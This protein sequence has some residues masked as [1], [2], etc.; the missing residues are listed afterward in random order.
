MKTSQIFYPPRFLQY[1]KAHFREKKRAYFWHFA[2]I[3]MMYFITLLMIGDDYATEIQELFYYFGFILTGFVF[4]LRYFSD[5]AKSE[6]C[7]IA[8]MRPASE[9][10]KW[11]LA[12]LVTLI[13][14]PI[15]YT[16]LFTVMTA[17]S[18]WLGAMTHS[19]YALEYQ[20]FIPLTNFEFGYD[21]RN[22][23]GI[24]Q[25]PL[26][27]FSIGLN[28]YALTTS[29]FFKRYPMIKSAALAFILFLMCIFLSSVITPDL[30]KIGD[31]WFN[32]NTVDFHL[33][34]FILG[35]MLWFVAPTL[36]L[37]SSFFAL[38]GR[39]L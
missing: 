25:I 21:W 29:L 12:V 19:E 13:L 14:Y 38:K 6:S 7:L 18:S 27:L 39:D 10:E 30:E 17:P 9:L 4:T 3:A 28:S 5:L 2:I 34:A 16:L 23:S 26:W 20:L 24:E 33:R 22:I 8:M 35:I 1:A 36:M 15:V 31:Y 11:L 32:S 37:L